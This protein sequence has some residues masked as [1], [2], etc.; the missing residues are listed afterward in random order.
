[1]KHMVSCICE[2]SATVGRCNG[3][4]GFLSLE[5]ALSARMGGRQRCGSMGGGR[6]GPK[7]LRPG[8]DSDYTGGACG[9]M[10]PT[11]SKEEGGV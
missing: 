3:K 6:Q 4:L 1:M 11:G 2:L 10:T 8:S 7:A 9:G 5:P